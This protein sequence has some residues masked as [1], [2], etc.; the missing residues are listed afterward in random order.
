MAVNVQRLFPLRQARERRRNLSYYLRLDGSRYLL[1]VAVLLG[2]MSMIALGQTGVV[3]TKGYAI[4][5]LEHEQTRLLRE[6]SQLQMRL[7]G[8]Q[9]LENIRS[10]A[11]QIGLRPRTREQ[12]RYL[13][14]DTPTL[15]IPGAPEPT[16]SETTR[17]DPKPTE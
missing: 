10:R 6:H 2:L 4:V 7:A 1:G 5:Q 13:V 11:E 12:E 3:A 14:L 8:A 15:A 16:A 17:T 9:S